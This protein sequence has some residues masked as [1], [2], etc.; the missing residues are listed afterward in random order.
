M[1]LLDL[2]CVLSFRV[3]IFAFYHDAL[4]K[5]LLPNSEFSFLC[6]KCY[7]T[8]WS[9]TCQKFSKFECSKYYENFHA[10]DTLKKEKG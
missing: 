8:A 4:C 10:R 3:F 6:Y 1:L 2:Q 5:I 9:I 7:V